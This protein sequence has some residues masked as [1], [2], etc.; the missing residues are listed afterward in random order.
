V[1]AGLLGQLTEYLRS[2]LPQEGC[3]FLLGHGGRASR[4]VPAPNA[5]GSHARFGVGPQFLFDLFRQLRAAG[6][7][8]VAICHSHPSGPARPS[9]VDIREAHYPQS[10]Y[11]IV[12]F[13]GDPEIRAWRISDGQVL[14]AEIHASC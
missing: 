9:S 13:A 12:S 7:D 4:F 1:D 8:L 5:L 11:V 6:E 10:F 14:E 3:G 2:C